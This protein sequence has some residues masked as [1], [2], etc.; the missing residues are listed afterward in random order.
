MPRSSKSVV[1]LSNDDTGLWFICYKDNIFLLDEG[2]DINRVW[3]YFKDHPEMYNRGKFVSDK[4]DGGDFYEFMTY[5]SEL[6][7]DVLVGM[8]NLSDRILTLDSRQSF[9]PRSS[10]VLKK[11]VKELKIKKVYANVL[12]YDGDDKDISYS[13]KSIGG[14]VPTTVYHGTTSKYLVNIL[15]FGLRPNQVGSNW[16]HRGI[17]NENEIFFAADFHTCEFYAHNSVNQQKGGI[18]I[19]FE[20]NIPDKNLLKPDYDADTHST[21]QQ[22]YS[23][24]VSNLPKTDMKP[25]T[26]SREQGKWGYSG[27]IPES[28]IRW[29]YMFR[30]GDKKWIKFR[31]STILNVLNKR[32]GDGMYKYG[33]EMYEGRI[34]LGDLIMENLELSN[35]D[36]N[37]I[38]ALQKDSGINILSDKEL[39]DIIREN[40]K[41]VGALWT[42]WDNDTFSF[43]I[44]VHPKFRNK[45][46][47]KQ[48]IKMALSQ[49]ND[50]KEAYNNPKLEVD[51]VNPHMEE[52][53]KK[54][55]GFKELSRIGGHVIL[56][57]ENINEA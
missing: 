23:H 7:P 45:G 34:K 13:K 15:K 16:G 33:F 10:L 25:M 37:D 49:F 40:D 21:K 38:T 44:I 6:A 27:R 31:P 11:V 26:V 50:E 18:P 22:Y 5:V 36:Y 8:V 42:S 47:A 14:D 48:L 30:D 57:K 43:D 29:V 32:G 9:S 55:F 46:Y 24:D 3:Q 1:K 17:Y 19:I 53:L 56:G 20:F 41:I 51:A 39:S 2:S 28:F 35:D 4:H 52:M 54:H 12:T